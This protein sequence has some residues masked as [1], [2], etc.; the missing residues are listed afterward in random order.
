M[1]YLSGDEEKLA[2]EYIIR[3][4]EIA[5]SSTCGRSR[6][7][8]VIVRDGEIIGSGFNSP[9]RGLKNQ[10]RC[11]C[12]KDFYHKKVVDKTC[13]VHVEQRAIMDALK[14]NPGK[15]AGSRL[16]F[17]RLDGEGNATRAGKP[18]CTLCSKMALDAEIA[19]FVLWH[20]EGVCV[21]DTEEYNTLSYQ[22]TE[23]FSNFMSKESSQLDIE[24]FGDYELMEGNI[25]QLEP[26]V[27]M[28]Y[29]IFRGM[30]EKEPYSLAQYQEKLK[31]NK[32]TIY[33][34]K[35][36]G[37]IIGD[38]ISFGKDKALYLWIMG[39]LKEHRNQGIA[40]QLFERTER[41]A[42]ANGYDSVTT[43]VYNVSGEM[44][45]VLVARGYQI[46]DVEKSDT[47]PK[48]NAVHLELKF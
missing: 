11:E 21:Y 47:D 40:T 10:R 37:Q 3:S 41:F 2:L 18:Y 8:S 31:D 17:I 27:A 22:Y 5:K 7:G 29:E 46:I 16:Y 9:P 25:D 20:E 43:K 13:C 4:V 24:R 15:L 6:C 34:A 14:N 12:L 44:R 35:M 32:V 23:Q 45:R 42:R 48:F 30:F 19:E 26:I 39:V 36:N 33:V 38:A 28:N 1:K